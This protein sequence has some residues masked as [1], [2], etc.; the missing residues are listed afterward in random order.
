[1]KRVL[2]IVVA[3]LLLLPLAGCGVRKKVAD[4]VTDKIS[5]GI[6]EKVLG[7]DVDVDLEDGKITV[8][9]DDGAEWTMG[10]GEWPKDGKA[11]QIPVFKK[12]KIG[13]I[14]NAEDNCWMEIEEVEE[15]EYLQYVED[16]KG[17]GFDANGSEYSDESSLMY[18]AYKGEE[19][20]I[21][22]TFSKDRD[23]MIIQVL[24]PSE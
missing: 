16:L 1:M 24:T 7:E 23:E 8:K 17:A 22:V 13:S 12:G 2:V 21:T 6:M 3:L 9:G 15:A 11:A 10:G 18:S 4:K 19:S 5:E 20:L 14:F